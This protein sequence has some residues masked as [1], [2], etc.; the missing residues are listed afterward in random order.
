MMAAGYSYVLANSSMPGLVKV[1]KTTRAPSDRA[2]ELSGVTG[3]ATPFIV[4]YEDYFEDCD[5]VESF[6][7]TK[8]GQHGVRV[9]ET[10]EF[11]RAS[12]SEVLKI[13]TAIGPAVSKRGWVAMILRGC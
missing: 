3:V 13:I 9:S 11:F 7:H 1:G 6:V 8:L 5:A 12:V 10:R 2:D 4:V